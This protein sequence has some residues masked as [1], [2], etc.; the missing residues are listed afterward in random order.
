[1]TVQSMTGFARHTATFTP[2]SGAETR[3]SWEIRCVNGKGLDA[4]FRTPNGFD[5][6]E[7]LLRAALG[8]VFSRGSFQVNVTVEEPEA[9]VKLV[10][11]EALLS[12]VMQ[13]A[14]Q[15]Q[16]QY[17][18]A[19]ASVDAVLNLKGILE[20]PQTEADE[21]AKAALKAVLLSSF[22]EALAALKLMR[23]QE[24][25]RLSDLLSG[26]VDRIAELAGQARQDVS[27]SPEAIRERLAGQVALLLEAVNNNRASAIALD[28]QRLHMEAAFLATKADIQEELDR[29]DM[30]VDAAHKLLADGGPV[31]RKLDFLS[32]E[33]NR[34]T[35]TLCSKS[36]AASITA[37]GLE[38]KAVVDQFREQIQNLE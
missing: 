13:T 35:N 26:H 29:L 28:E 3:I 9:Q 8:R 38:L 24:G 22:D 36:N 20:P 2:E 6:L 11:N 14:Q 37:I 34:E 5:D 10:I 1:M 30:H 21:N 4:R 7:Q 23:S 16:N 17:G 12:K 18:L 15:L 25:Q 19:P 31:G 33:F 32:Q 27:R